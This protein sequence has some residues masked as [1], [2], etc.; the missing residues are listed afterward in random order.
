MCCLTE[1]TYGARSLELWIDFQDPQPSGSAAFQ[2][3]HLF[4]RSRLTSN[5]SHLTSSHLIPSFA[6]SRDGKRLAISR[7]SASLDVVLIKDFR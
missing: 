5:I 2:T 6:V 1:T 4:S 7:G 3:Q